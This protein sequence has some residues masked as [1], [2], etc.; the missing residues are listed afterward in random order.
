MSLARRSYA[1][2]S[3]ANQASI[4]RALKQLPGVTVEVIERPVDLLIGYKGRNWL[5]ELKTEGGKLNK[6]QQ[7]F[8]GTW[9]GQCAVCRSLDEVLEL[10]GL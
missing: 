1:N 5:V 10:L 4:V 6:S 8:F 9:S 7:K 2:R 3:D